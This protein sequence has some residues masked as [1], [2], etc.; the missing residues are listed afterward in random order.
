MIVV[1][2]LG[3]ALLTWAAVS[4]TGRGGVRRFLHK[5]AIVSL[6]GAA[7]VVAAH[8]ADGARVVIAYE[9]WVAALAI[10]HGGLLGALVAARVRAGIVWAVSA[11]TFVAA[12]PVSVVVQ[13]LSY[14]TFAGCA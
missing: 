11:A 4:A 8:A 14:C 6:T 2:A 7:L 10:L 5:A 13:Y 12:V 1:H 9:A 3:V